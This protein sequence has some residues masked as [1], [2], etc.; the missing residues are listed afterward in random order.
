MFFIWVEK[1]FFR[2]KCMFFI[3]ANEID[4]EVA[5]LG[6]DESRSDHSIT[7]NLKILS[8][9]IKQNNLLGLLITVEDCFIQREVL[10][11]K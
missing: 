8:K 5:N 2:N 4:D 6:Y 9:K 7:D 1:A 11:K 3:K 10:N